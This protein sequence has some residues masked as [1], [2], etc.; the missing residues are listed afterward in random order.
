MPVA[1]NDDTATGDVNLNEEGTLETETLPE[2]VIGGA[3][4]PFIGDGANLDLSGTESWTEGTEVYDA[5]SEETEVPMVPIDQSSEAP[6][7]D[8]SAD[9]DGIN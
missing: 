3:G 4:S 2:G 7:A 6:I 5:D 8:D 1:Y 9:S